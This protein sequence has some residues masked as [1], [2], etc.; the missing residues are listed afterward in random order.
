MKAAVV[1]WSGTG[2]TEAMAKAIAEGMKEAGAEV[3]LGDVSQ[4]TKDSLLEYEKIALGCPAMGD[5]ELEPNEFE[6]FYSDVEGSLSGKTV[7]LFGSY[8]WADGKWMELWED[9]AS[10]KGITVFDNGGII[11]FEAPDSAMEATLKSKGK[12]FIG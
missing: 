9:R 1:Y 2:N 12:A 5:E 7:M 11:C 10:K 4:F 3:K 8:S 6:P